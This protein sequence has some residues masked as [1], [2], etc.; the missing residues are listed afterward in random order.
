MEDYNNP[1]FAQA[2]IE[3]TKQLQDVLMNPIYEGLLS[4]YGESKKDYSNYT[5]IS[6]YKIFRKKIENIPKW[7]TDMIDEEVDRIIRVS[8]CD[9]LEDLITAVFISHTKILA[10]IGNQRT[11]KINLTIPK[12]TNFIHKCYIN[13]AREVWKN[14]YL[15]DENVSSSEY[16]KNIKLIESLIKENID[17]TIRKLLPVRDILR[18]HLEN[19]DIQNPNIEEET[20]ESKTRDI[21]KMLMDELINLKRRDQYD[22]YAVETNEKYFDDHV[23]DKMIEENTKNIE[24]NDIVTNNEEIY[25]NPDIIEAKKDIDKN[26][27]EELNNY[28]NIIEDNKDKVETILPEITTSIIADIN[29]EPEPEQISPS[30]PLDETDKN[31]IAT[32]TIENEVKDEVNDEVKDEVND[33]IK[34]DNVKIIQTTKGAGKVEIIEKEDDTLDNF[35]D[36]MTNMLKDSDVEVKNDKGEYNLFDDANDI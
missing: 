19:T 7:N 30:K 17:Q 36:D 14:P 31:I 32:T 23:D 13:T 15:F 25:D 22:K 6:M 9:W 4:I 16:Q 21:Q 24:I 18:D 10:S 8:K 20:E 5:E 27:E 29:S 28:K 26:V 35:M 3:Y 1:V 11:K 2:K 34:D 12:I 33:E